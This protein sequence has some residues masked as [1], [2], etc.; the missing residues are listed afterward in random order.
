MIDEHQL[1]DLVYSPV[2]LT[3]VKHPRYPRSYSMTRTN[4]G[5]GVGITDYE[6]KGTPASIVRIDNPGQTLLLSEKFASNN[7]YG[8]YAHCVIDHP[9]QAT[10]FTPDR[11]KYNYLFVDGHVES[12]RPE[13]TIGDG[14][15]PKPQGYWTVDSSD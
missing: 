11:D 1:K 7:V 5:K 8:S 4:Y 15:L 9:Q 6:S 2:H 14:T 13:Q 3:N 12:L 10:D